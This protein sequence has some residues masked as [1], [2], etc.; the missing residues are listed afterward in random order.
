MRIVVI[1]I[2]VRGIGI[3]DRVEVEVEVEVVII[4]VGGEIKL[5]DKRSRVIKAILVVAIRK[6]KQ[7]LQE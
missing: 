1:I 2:I 7:E 6:E 4:V 3:V 5:G